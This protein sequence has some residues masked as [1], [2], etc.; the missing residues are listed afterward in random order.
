MTGRDPAAKALAG[1]LL[2]GGAVAL[3]AGV[4][5]RLHEPTSRAI[6]LAGFSSPGAAKSWLATAVIVLVGV[7]VFT[8]A[9]MWGQLG[10]PRWAGPVHRWSGRLALLA[11]LPVAVHCLYALGLQTGDFR[12]L[13]HSL[14]GCFVLGAIVTKLIVLPRHDLP[15]LTLPLL[16]GLVALLLTAVWLTSAVWFFTTFGLVV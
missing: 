7:Q 9:G 15:A 2:A 16:G 11:M 6:N 3:A 14:A 5:G 1:A 4:Y 12:V 10:A 13:V 8:A